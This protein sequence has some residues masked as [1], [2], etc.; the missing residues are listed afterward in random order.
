MSNPRIEK[1]LAKKKAIEAQI[2]REQNRDRARD[3]KADTRRKILAGAWVLAETEKRPDFKEFVL[4]QLDR[5]L[6]RA[7]ERALFD[8]PPLPQGDASAPHHPLPPGPADK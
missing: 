3:R 7:D 4:Q 5:F 2:R 1:L 6:R 8:L